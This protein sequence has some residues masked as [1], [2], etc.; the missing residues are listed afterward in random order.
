M[1]PNDELYHYGIKGMKWGIRRTPEQLGH[2]T[3]K[4]G[5]AA[6]SAGKAIGSAA[7]KAGSAISKKAAESKQNREAKKK[8]DE[9]VK[10]TQANSKKKISDLT[11][12]ELRDRIQRMQLENQYRSLMPRQE[13]KGKAF[14]STVA[15]QVIKPAATNAAR[16][17]LEKQLKSALGLN[18]SGNSDPLKK[19]REEADRATLQNRKEAAEEQIRNRAAKRAAESNS[20]NDNSSGS[21]NDTSN[22]S[23]NNSSRS[24]RSDTFDDVIEITDFTVEDVPITVTNAGRVYSQNV[25]GGMSVAGLLGSGEKRK[26]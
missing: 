21:S 19:L 20:N 18:D 1:D 3:K 12:D 5:D 26:K 11:N 8:H 4:V 9:E 24:S 16:Q 17:Y 22:K 15:N 6:S 2:V 10:K 23:N 13:S 14:V 7:K 25:L